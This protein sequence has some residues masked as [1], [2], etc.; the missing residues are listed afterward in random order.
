ML[1]RSEL[2]DYWDGLVDL[3]TIT[4][5]LT[6]IGHSQDLIVEKIQWGKQ[7]VIKSG[8][9]T[10]IDCFYQIWADRLGEKLI[11][12]YEGSTPK[13]YPGDNSEY[14]IAG[15]DYDNRS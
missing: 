8:S 13:D 4:V 2:P 6:Q 5:N 12:E 3:E 10:S 15:W 14:S 11:V 7:I 1:F 9:G